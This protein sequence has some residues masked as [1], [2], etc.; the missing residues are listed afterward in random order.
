MRARAVGGPVGSRGWRSN[1]ASP[2][3][4][5]LGELNDRVFGGPVEDGDTAHLLY[6][7]GRGAGAQGF[8]HDAAL[9]L[10]ALLKADL[11]QLVVGKGLVGGGNDGLADPGIA[12]LYNW[13][14][15]M[16]PAPEEP[17]LLAG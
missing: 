16:G 9:G 10:V 4:S 5:R 15:V 14:E 7:V 8:R 13:L 12:H 2:A 6:Q 17:V 3:A 1:G 11:D